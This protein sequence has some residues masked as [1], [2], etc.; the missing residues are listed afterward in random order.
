M[1]QQVTALAARPGDLNSVPEIQGREDYSNKL[2]FNPT[3]A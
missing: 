1:A 2:C 3:R